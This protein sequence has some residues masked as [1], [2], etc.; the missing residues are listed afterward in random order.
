[1]VFSSLIFLFLFL[2]GVKLAHFVFFKRIKLQNFI[3]MLFSLSFYYWGEKDHIFIMLACILIN[4]LCGLFIEQSSQP[5]Y[6]RLYLLTSIVAS[7]SLLMY[8]KYFNFFLSSVNN[9]F[10]LDVAGIGEIALPLGISF[11]TFHAL[12]YV[13]DVYWNKVKAERNLITFICYVSFF[14][15]LV[16]GPIV[17][18]SDIRHSFYCRYI[19]RAG[20][21]NGILRFCFGLGKKVLIANEVARLADYAFSLPHNELT[22]AIAWLGA[23]AYALQI[24]FDFSGYSDMAIGLGLMFGF[25]Y[26]E[27][28]KFPY[29]AL[30]I[31]EFWR[32]W[33]ISL[34]S[35][36]RDYV[37]IPLGGSH[38]SRIRTYANLIIIFGLCGLWHGANYTFI[39]WGLFHGLFLIL[40]R[41]KFGRFMEQLPKFMRHGYVLLVVTIGWVFF[42]EEHLGDAFLFIK[43]MLIPADF[44]I[45]ALGTCLNYLVI[46]SACLGILLSLGATK[47]ARDFLIINRNRKLIVA[48]KQLTII[49]ALSIFLVSIVFLSTNSYNPFLYFKF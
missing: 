37:Y 18:Y 10:N 46:T 1:M 19:T 43:M 27:N 12:S 41:T 34:S 22:F 6:R 16:A 8:F 13:I 35:W 25:K 24:Y 5:K 28:F 20:L 48:Y 26:K 40:E 14:P 2:P 7:L 29:N 11:Y 4:Y 44:S 42:R 33:H 38:A 15:Q 47:W 17:R 30:S 21:R 31:Q 36:F 23:I 49:L 3:L 45:K 9:L 32:K 39:L